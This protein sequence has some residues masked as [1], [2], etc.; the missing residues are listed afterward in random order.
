MLFEANSGWG[1]SSVILACVNRLEEQGHFAVAIDT[2]SASRAQ[3]VLKTLQHV[4]DK[5]GNFEGVLKEKKSI[6]GYE[7]AMSSL[8]EIG[9]LLENEGKLLFLFFDQFENVFH[10]SD[11]L[12]TITRMCLKVS[13]ANTNVLLGFAWKTDLIGLTREFP[14]RQRDIIIDSSKIFYPQKFTEKETDI[15]LDKLSDELHAPLRKDL[16]FLLS[17]FSQGYP[18]LLKKLCAHVNNQRLSGV[19]QAEIARGLLNVEELFNTDLSGLSSE[20]EATLRKI[21]K[22]A[23]VSFSE[24]GDDFSPEVIQSLIHRRLIVNVGAKYDIY[25]DI[26]RDFLNTGNV[27]I[28]EHYMLRTQV[29]SVLK[30]IS[31]LREY[32]GSLSI[33]EFQAHAGISSENSFHNIARDMH[34][35]DLARVI[36]SQV[37]LTLKLKE[38][39]HQFNLHLREHLRGRLKRN[40]VVK[41]I[42]DELND[43]N[44]LSLSDIVDIIK[45]SFGYISAN[46]KTWFTYSKVL[47]YWLDVS[48]IAIFDPN[49][50]TLLNYKPGSEIR[51]RKL[52]LARKRGTVSYLRIQFRPVLRAAEIINRAI[53]KREPVDWSVLSRT[54]VYKALAALEDLK[55]IHRK[56]QTIAVAPELEMFVEDEDFRFH[57]VK[58]SIL[59]RRIFNNFLI[60]L[61]EYKN[62]PILQKEIGE[63]LC[64]RLNLNWSSS[65][66]EVNAKIMLDWARHF[67]LAPGRFAI[68]RRGRP[69]KT[70]AK[71]ELT[72]FSTDKYR[73]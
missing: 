59:K 6:T 24:L 28:Q 16:R 21:A 48:D 64:K 62:R 71:G 30:A 57:L 67:G 51:E 9:K 12:D 37:T 50:K 63:E 10:I 25:W 56:A 49:T 34:I 43:K 20:E 26:F 52:I 4:H 7:G 65:T 17:E 66:G 13:D 11:L 27:P 54:T 18:W 33:E 70:K 32:D 72:L 8:I 44:F 60:I 5:F 40:Q 29:G 46:L 3:F 61:E 39:E 15:L 68:S 1:K 47:M 2:R 55:L 53:A 35:L 45:K 42:V 14:Y 41:I 73:S 69:K 58:N 19:L 38:D 36:D 22:M 23:P 31:I